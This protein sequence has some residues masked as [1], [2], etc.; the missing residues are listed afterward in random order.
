MRRKCP[1]CKSLDIRR[2]VPSRRDGRASLLRSRLRCRD[3][4]ETFW[5][6][7]RKAYRLLGFFVH[8]NAAFFALIATVLFVYRS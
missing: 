8:I 1:G 5:V 2:C 6:V 4:K 7:N 3:C